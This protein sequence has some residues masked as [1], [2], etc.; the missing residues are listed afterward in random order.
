M[1]TKLIL[2]GA[3]F[4]ISLSAT[5]QIEKGTILANGSAS[6]SFSSY[7]DIEDGVTESDSKTT[8]FWLTPRAGLFFTDALLVGIGIGFSGGMTKYDDGDKYSYSSVSFTPYVRYYLPQ[9]FFGQLEIGPGINTDKWEFDSGTDDEDKYKVFTWSI[10]AGYAFFLND[11]IALEPMIS[12][13][14]TNYTDS[15]NTDQKD[16]YGTLGFHMGLS[17]YFDRP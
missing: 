3:A 16:K 8:S 1:N 14:A 5:A 10:G 13:A 11:N 2:S 9:G 4:C 7:R 6:L 15:N 17:I 12:Y